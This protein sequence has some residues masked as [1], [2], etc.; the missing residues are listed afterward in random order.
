MI[1]KELIAKIKEELNKVELMPSST[2]FDAEIRIKEKRKCPVCESYDFV[3]SGFL[4]EY[5]K[6]NK[7]S[8]EFIGER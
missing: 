3:T 4:V 6:C 8:Y 7:C 1:K 2:L 5:E